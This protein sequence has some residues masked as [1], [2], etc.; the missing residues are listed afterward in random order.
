[1]VLF[2]SSIILVATVA[3]AVWTTYTCNRW[4]VM[5]RSWAI[6]TRDDRLALT[7]LY[8]AM[9]D[10]RE[11]V[12]EVHQHTVALAVEMGLIPETYEEWEES[13]LPKDRVH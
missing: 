4:M 8:D 6:E 3:I 10:A 1:M 12:N 5:C 2:V 11:Q 13:M 7:E 9:E